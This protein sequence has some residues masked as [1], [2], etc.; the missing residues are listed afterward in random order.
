MAIHIFK[1]TYGITIDINTGVDLTGNTS[2]SLSIKNPN[3]VLSTSS[4]TIADSALGIVRYTTKQSDFPEQ[5][6]Y[7]IQAVI[8]F[9][10]SVKLRSQWLAVAVDS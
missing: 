5:G 4:L 7:W 6:A 2:I 9:G 10:A 3:G 1:D 8:E